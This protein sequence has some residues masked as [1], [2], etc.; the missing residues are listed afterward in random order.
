MALLAG[1]RGHF[2]TESGYHSEWWFELDRL[3]DEPAR[4][5]PFVVQLAQ[6]LAD[7]RVEVICGPMTGGALL[8]E[9]VAAELG[10]TYVFT[11]RIVPAGKSG[12][13]PVAYR[14]PEVHRAGLRGRT[15][16]IV[17]DAVSAGSAARG[18]YADLIACEARP[19]V[20]GALFA[21]GPAAAQLA[22][23]HQ[24]GL[25]ALASLPLGV[26]RPEECP[27]CRAGLPLEALTDV[28]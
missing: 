13:F 22:A 16:A 24:L 17:D 10:C 3:F 14:V 7:Y 6:Q 5:Q 1:R 28:P 11:E 26:W 12:L 18:T 8:A 19:A 15:I 21:F 20:L 4:L 27:H 25:V 23:A 2:K 9:R